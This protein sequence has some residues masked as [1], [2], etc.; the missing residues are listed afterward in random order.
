MPTKARITMLFGY[1]AIP[2]FC[3]KPK[4]GSTK[5][6]RKRWKEMGETNFPSVTVGDR[7]GEYDSRGLFLEQAHVVIRERNLIIV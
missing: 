1:F 3:G 7:M 2:S 5:A 4:L 6:R